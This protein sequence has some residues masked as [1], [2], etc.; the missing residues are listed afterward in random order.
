MQT[1]PAT[2]PVVVVVGDLIA[3]RYRALLCES[4][5]CSGSE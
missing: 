3:P 1:R 4:Y 2:N 5:M